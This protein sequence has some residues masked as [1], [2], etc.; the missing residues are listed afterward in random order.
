MPGG[1]A[2][3]NPDAGE[4]RARMQSDE[5]QGVTAATRTRART[6]RAEPRAPRTPDAA[7]PATGA[8]PGRG[9][10]P[11]RDAGAGASRSVRRALV[12][13]R[14][15]RSRVARRAD[16]RSP[17]GAH[18]L[19]A[20][21]APPGDGS[22]RPRPASTRAARRRTHAVRLEPAPEGGRRRRRRRA[23]LAVPRA[24]RGATAHARRARRR[25]PRAVAGPRRVRRSATRCTCSRRCR[26]RPEASGGDRAVGVH[27]RRA[28]AREAGRGRHG[29]RRPVPAVPC[30]VRARHGRRRAELVR[31]LRA[32]GGVRAAPPEPPDLP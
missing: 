6:P 22:R 29:A 10:A 28:V 16:R 8:R 15:V 31:P 11:R 32:E 27:D 4:L 17:R 26:S 2:R 14:S 30:C 13:T 18:D 21:D 20:G 3:R 5:E 24:V 12:A 19:A 7:P 1:R 25:D 23:S 9:R